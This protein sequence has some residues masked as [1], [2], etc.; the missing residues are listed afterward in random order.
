MTNYK[1]DQGRM[2]RM[3]V[4][5]GCAA[6][7]LFGC[8][9]LHT[10]LAANFAALSSPIAGIRI[11]IVGVDLSGAFLISTALLAILLVVIHR[12]QQRPKTADL[13]IDTEAELKKVTWPT[14]NEV[15]NSSVVVIIFVLV[16]MG[17]LAGTD[18]L[19]GNIFTRI[20]LG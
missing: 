1:P 8:T 13:L 10:L 9:S 7:S 19:L 2:V 18:Y 17:Y 11:P 15:I 20:L 3:A 6:L 16:L 5:W 14:L 4:F 12:W